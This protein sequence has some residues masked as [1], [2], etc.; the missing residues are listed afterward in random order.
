LDLCSIK[1][2][3]NWAIKQLH[4]S[5]TPQLDAQLLMMHVLQCTRVYLFTQDQ[6]D[7]NQQQISSFKKLV[8]RRMHHEPIAYLLG[9]KQFWSLDLI[10][11]PQTLI[12]RA[13]TELLVALCL[14]KLPKTSI[15]VADLGTGCGAIAIALAIMRP[16]WHIVATDISHDALIVAQHNSRRFNLNQ[17]EFRQGDWC[18]ALAGEKFHAIVSNPP[19]VALQDYEDT[20][21]LQHEPRSA[22]VSDPSD[23]QLARIIQQANKHLLH[24]GYLLLEHGYDQ[25]AAVRKYFM[26]S[27]YCALEQHDDIAHTT[28]VQSAKWN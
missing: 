9:I 10:V 2:Q 27:R 15:R 5:S 4:A 1:A 3:L 23:A 7:L 19:Y 12:P 20:P 8:M 25:A 26:E 28:R 16:N 11:T 14:E 17:L 22:L 18:Q 21:Q 13:E 6:T 24:G